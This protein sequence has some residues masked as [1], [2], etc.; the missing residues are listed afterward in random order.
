MAG[1]AVRGYDEDLSLEISTHTPERRR[2]DGAPDSCFFL[3]PQGRCRPAVNEH[4]PVNFHPAQAKLGR[5]TCFAQG[6]GEF[7]FCFFLAESGA[8]QEFTHLYRYMGSCWSSD[9]LPAR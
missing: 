8:L 5:G 4:G 3:V 2:K 6:F 9:R 1:G 7:T